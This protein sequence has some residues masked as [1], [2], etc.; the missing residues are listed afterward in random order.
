MS[1]VNNLQIWHSLEVTDPNFTKPFSRSGGFSGTAINSAYVLRKLSEAFGPCGVGWRFV[2]ENEQYVEGHALGAQPTDKDGSLH[3]VNRSIIHV[4]RGH[5]DYK[6]PGTD[7]W[8]STGPQFGQTTFVGE[9]KYGPFTDEEAPK[10]SITDCLS[11]CA[12]L[13]GVSADVHMGA[14]DDNKYLNEYGAPQVQALPQTMPVIPPGVIPPT[15]TAVPAKRG[16]KTKAQLQV[17]ASQTSVVQ[18][19]RDG[20][21]SVSGMNIPAMP[22][23]PGV[24]TGG[25]EHWSA[26]QWVAFTAQRSS[27]DL[28]TAFERAIANPALHD[29]QGNWP[30]ICNIFADR[31]RAVMSPEAAERPRMVALMN[32]ERERITGWLGQMATGTVAT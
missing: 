27:A 20:A 17:E 2:L 1:N 28:M 3:V 15:T 31:A 18:L 21:Q 23:S 6:L 30:T 8:L 16:R 7:E 9:N 32:S 19:P 26:E 24:V 11:K 29:N 4:V 22:V 5:I 13:L 10:K 14:F 12:L 25:A